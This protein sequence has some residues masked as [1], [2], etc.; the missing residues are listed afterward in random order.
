MHGTMDVMDRTG[1]TTIKWDPAIPVE[2]A[3]ARASFDRLTGDGYQAF[4]VGPGE[5]MSTRLHAFD[6]QA[7]K[8]ILVPHLQGG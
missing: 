5:E 3:M 7:T 4:R 6:P 2:V 1:H 8:M